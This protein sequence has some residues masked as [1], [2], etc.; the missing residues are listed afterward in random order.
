[1]IYVT[2]DIHGNMKRFRSLMKKI[3]LQPGDTLYVLGDVMDRYPGGYRILRELLSMP[4]VRLLL[5]NH[6]YM[7]LDAIGTEYSEEETFLLYERM[8][9]WYRNGGRVTHVSFNHVPVAR[10]QEI[11]SILRE[12]PLYADVTAGGRTFRLIHGGD[13]EEYNPRYDRNYRDRTEFAVWYRIRG[14][15]DWRE[16]RT[17][18]FG[19]TPTYHY[20][21]ADPLSVWHSPDGRFIGIDCGCGFPQDGRAGNGRLACLRLD[22]LAE[23]YSDT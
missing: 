4:N 3:R 8:S 19:H 16:D 2:G 11:F 22:D 10:R 20:Q 21:N 14:D 18:V 13:P 12:L 23:F 15:E 7:L 9:R 1:M 5:G 6:E 17:Y